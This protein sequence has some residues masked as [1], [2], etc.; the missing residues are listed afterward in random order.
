MLETAAEAL[1][2]CCAGLG[3]V[4]LIELAAGEEDEVEDNLCWSKKSDGG[5]DRLGL[6]A[7]HES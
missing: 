3:A 1:L 4:V 5:L 7:K 6:E 2:G